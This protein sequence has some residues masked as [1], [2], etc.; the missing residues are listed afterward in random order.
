MKTKQHGVSLSVGQKLLAMGLVGVIGAGVVGWFGHVG[1]D[2]VDR[3]MGEQV[4][5]ATALRNHLESDMMHDALRGDVL[6]SLLAE[7]DDEKAQ[8]EA[9]LAEHSEWFRTMVAENK[10]LPLN[11]EVQGALDEVSG[12][13]DAYISSAES[14]IAIA[15]EQGPAVA[16]A[17]LPQFLEDFGTLETAMEEASDKISAASAAAEADASRQVDAANRNVLIVLVLVAIASL[18]LCFQIA[19][20]ITKPLRKAVDT[21]QRI[22][23]KDLTARLDV[24]TKDETGA[25]ATAL[26]SALV[27]LSGAMQAIDANSA[28]LATSSHELAAVSTQIAGAAEETSSQSMVVSAAGEEVSTN[29]ASVA[30]AVEEMAASVQEIAQSTSE[31]ARV[32]ADAVHLAAQTNAD[33]TRLGESSQEIGNVV[34]V[35]T[36]IAEQTNL[37]ALNATIEAA[38]AGES[39][40]GF[41]VVANEVKELANETAKATEDISRRI[42]EIQTDTGRSVESIQ[43]ISD[44][45]ARISDYQ[46]AIAGAVEEQAATTNEIGRSVSEAA[47]GSQEIASNISGVASAA[48]ST[49]DGVSTTQM[50]ANDL[51]VV[52]GELAELVGQFKY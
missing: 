39:G 44:I 23:G 11:G 18:G 8:V 35:I 9:D 48:Q 30:T 19:R 20:S 4:V 33:I 6:A 2:H 1:L 34:K 14:I 46:N 40:K 16:E 50:A 45:I 15:L 49:A 13:L 43:Q 32:A 52:A 22:A 31:A 42:A 28:R 36:A 27:S 29:V 26:N 21:L 17:D 5:T 24:T 12:P 47:R 51:G 25:M 7:T 10:K 3:S 38:R 41:A 37:L